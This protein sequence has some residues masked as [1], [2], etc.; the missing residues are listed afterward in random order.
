MES[1]LIRP[2]DIEI[3]PNG[4]GRLKK[5]PAKK[6]KKFESGKRKDLDN[7]YFRSRWEAN[8]ARYLNFLKKHGKIHKWEYETEEFEFHKIKRG[9]RFY[10]IDFKI[11][12]NEG[13]EPYY[14]EVKGYLDPSSKTKLKRMAKYYPHIKIHVIGKKEYNGIKQW[15]G[16][17]SGWES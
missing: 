12:D 3:L 4:R 2:E 6:E 11:W 8:V 13:S 7:M 17:I 9:N 5:D 1:N 10:R 16:I 14:W 15:A